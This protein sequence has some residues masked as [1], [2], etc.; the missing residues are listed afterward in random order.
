VILLNIQIS[1]DL[2][3]VDNIK[4]NITS[5]LGE[6]GAAVSAESSGLGHWLGN[7]SD[8]ISN[9][10]AEC[11]ELFDLGVRDLEELCDE[12]MTNQNRYVPHLS[13][14]VVNLVGGA[15]PLLQLQE[16]VSNPLFDQKENFSEFT[17]FLV[18]LVG[19]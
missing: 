7:V 1:K 2:D 12:L 16:L 6:L 3:L 4:E 11:G 14:G 10:I 15:S 19:I 13:V 5:L 9:I 17:N 8:A 18:D